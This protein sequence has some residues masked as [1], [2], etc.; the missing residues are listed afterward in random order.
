MLQARTEQPSSQT[1]V[2]QRKQR[3]STHRITSAYRTV[4]VVTFILNSYGRLSN[5][6]SHQHSL[7]HTATPYPQPPKL[8]RS[9]SPDF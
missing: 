2:T 6:M 1:N 8:S 3:A 9:H 5:L 7:T 4:C